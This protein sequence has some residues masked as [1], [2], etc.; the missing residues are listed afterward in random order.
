MKHQSKFNPEQQHTAAQQ[1]RQQTTREFTTAEE[2]LR[3]DASEVTVPPAIAQRL[4]QS[5]ADLPG[6]SK[7]WWRRLF[8]R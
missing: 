7:P 2:L 6:P 4:R 1:S 3:Y 8:G 5:S